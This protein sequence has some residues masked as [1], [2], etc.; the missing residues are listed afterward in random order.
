MIKKLLIL[1]ISTCIIPS[2]LM[3]DYPNTSIGVIDINKILAEA[4]AAV[5]AA[6]EIENI[7]AEIENEIKLS[8]EEIIKEQNLLIES[9]SIMAPEAFEAKRI[10]YEN[11]IQTY[12]S[13]RQSKLMKIDELI[14]ISRND[15]LNA[16]KPI[17]EEI[18]NEKGITIILEKTSIMLNAEKMDITNEVLKKLNK[19]LP[20]QYIILEISQN[21][22]KYQQERIRKEFPNH[23][24]IFKWIT[25]LED[26]KID[27]LIIANEF[28]DALPT[29]RFR[30]N[31]SK[32]ETLYIE[33]NNESLNYKWD[34]PLNNFT[35]ELS[36]A[37]NNHNIDFSDKYVSE[38]NLNYSK[39]INLIDKCM[40]SG[41][42]FIIDY[43]YPSQEYFLQDRCDG[44]LVCVH[45]HKS[46]F[47]PLLH[48]GN[49]DIS[50]FV[51]FSHLKNLSLSVLDQF[52]SVHY[53]P[54]DALQ[55]F[56]RLTQFFSMMAQT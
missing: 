40:K 23:Y 45:K 34:E 14:A 3:A 15:I 32:L 17:L 29:E 6:E 30:I 41:V 18:S 50:S 12:N 9:Q 19:S 8:D 55:N 13:E 7:A 38:L 53:Q 44:T 10:E 43:G 33:S 27:G 24:N 25:N 2:L 56:V 20:T 46:N 22:I 42:L 49:Q 16:I 21:L 11:K 52:S 37:K 26:I 36:K 51:N 31:N 48:I 47:D 54:L 4:N 1:I 35:N 5:E 39:W 28:F